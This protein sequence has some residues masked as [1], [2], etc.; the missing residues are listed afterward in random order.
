MGNNL[1]KIFTLSSIIHKLNKNRANNKTWEN[2]LQSFRDFREQR[3]KGKM[4]QNKYG[5]TVKLQSIIIFI[6]VI[7]YLRER[8]WKSETIHHHEVNLRKL[9][10]FVVVILFVYLKPKT[11]RKNGEIID[12]FRTRKSLRNKC[13]YLEGNRSRI[14][15]VVGIL[16]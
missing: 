9:P 11:W 3:K 7:I 13:Y 14:R 10:S 15:K 2:N 12:P 16:S 4:L 1:R 8:K 6:Y 5:R